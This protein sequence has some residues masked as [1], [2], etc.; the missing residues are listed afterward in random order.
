MIQQCYR[1]NTIY[2][3]KEPLE[4]KRVTHGLCEECYPKEMQRLQTELREVRRQRLMRGQRGAASIEYA[5]IA[6]LIA[7]VVIV[8]IAHFGEAVKGLFE[9][10]NALCPSAP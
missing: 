3:E 8:G 6:A 9:V 7:T 4:D 5:L 2:G 10:I 1:C